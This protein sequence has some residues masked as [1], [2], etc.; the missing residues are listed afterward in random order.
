MKGDRT[1]AITIPDQ[2]IGDGL[3]EHTKVVSVIGS[4][5]TGK[6][7]EFMPLDRKL[8]HTHNFVPETGREM[9]RIKGT[10]T[11]PDGSDDLYELVLRRPTDGE[12]NLWQA[13]FWNPQYKGHD[14]IE[15]K[16][17]YKPITDIDGSTRWTFTTRKDDLT[18][19]EWLA[20]FHAMDV[21]KTIQ[22]HP[23]VSCV[24]VGGEGK[25]TPFVIVEPKHHDFVGEKA[26]ALLSDL[27]KLLSKNGNHAEIK[28]PKETIFV[29]KS[30]K[31][32]KR[33]LKQTLMRKEIEKD[34]S[35]EIEEAYVRLSKVELQMNDCNEHGMG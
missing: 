25:P 17:L 27:Y 18:K 4:T 28:I 12:P 32:L 20:K 19:L 14:I 7:A 23:N 24:F 34:Y 1:D 29:T 3:I 16:E 8:W 11:E 6:Q 10:G 33:S 21:E 9:V 5:E 30:G 2:K 35:V 26:E 31:P 13:A 22:Q 15:T